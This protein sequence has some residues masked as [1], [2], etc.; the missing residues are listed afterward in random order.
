MKICSSKTT[1]PIRQTDGVVHLI[2]GYYVSSDVF[3]TFKFAVVKHYSM[4]KIVEIAVGVEV[5]YSKT[6][7]RAV[8]MGDNVLRQYTLKQFKH[9]L[10]RV[11][12]MKGNIKERR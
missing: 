5:C 4:W 3:P 9:G 7:K 1:I 11:Y 12:K 8:E 6:R 2:D 10:K